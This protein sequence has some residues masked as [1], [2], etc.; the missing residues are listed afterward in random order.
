MLGMRWTVGVVVLLGACGGDDDGGRPM[1]DFTDAGAPS[2]QDA[3]QRPPMDAG[4]IVR[5]DAGS[6]VRVDA[7]SIVRV[8]A[9]MPGVDAG[10]VMPDAGVPGDGPVGSQCA[11]GADCM[12]AVCL[13]NFFSIIMLPG[14][15]CSASC[16]GAGSCGEGADCLPL[17]SQCAQTCADDSECRTGEGYSCTELPSIP[18]V[19][20][21]QR[22]CLPGLGLPGGD[23][24]LP[25]PIPGPDGGVGD[26]GSTPT[27]DAGA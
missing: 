27:P 9:G 1:L 13:D 11:S 8:D 16:A 5:V 22:F 25:F 10:R 15:Y 3:G 19:G 21:A 6:I 14:G 7:G 17:V 23:G 2:T 26:A 4:P 12:G 20:T 18:G 24:G